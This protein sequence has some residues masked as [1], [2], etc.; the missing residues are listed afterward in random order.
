[1][2][3]LRGD[4]ERPWT[5]EE[6][7]RELHVEQGMKGPAL[8]DELG[9]TKQTIYRWLEK[10]G[11]KQSAAERAD[12]SKPYHDK[13][14]LRR[15]YR[16][17]R[18]TPREIADKFG[19]HY[20]T[21]H[22]WLDHFEIEAMSQS[23]RVSFEP[24]RY[25]TD[26]RGYARWRTEYKGEQRYVYVHQLL[27]VAE[28]ADPHE[29]FSGG[30]KQ[31]HHKNELKWANWPDN[32]EFLSDSDHGKQHPERGKETWFTADDSRPGGRVRR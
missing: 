8:A 31:V 13:E 20:Q 25:E 16:D 32:I 2:K 15:M 12:G 23:D 28:G 26:D 21:V 14:R 9:T 7:M 10:H 5:D 27:A 18:M 4:G 30:L 1:M 6:L 22:D 24:A 29:V 11:L 17:K 19:C 3:P